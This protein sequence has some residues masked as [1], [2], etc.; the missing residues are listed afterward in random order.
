MYLNLLDAGLNEHQVEDVRRFN[1]VVGQRRNWPR[2]SGGI[3]NPNGLLPNLTFPLVLPYSLGRFNL[4]WHRAADRHCQIAVDE[5]RRRSTPSEC[6]TLESCPLLRSA[7]LAQHATG[8]HA[9][10]WAGEGLLDSLHS[11]AWMRQ[12]I[13]K[14]LSPLECYRDPQVLWPLRSRSRASRVCRHLAVVSRGSAMAAYL[15]VGRV[16]WIRRRYKR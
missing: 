4:L 8:N 14:H 3:Q 11:M 2:F 1:G 16:G 6:R 10:R 7:Y 12:A 13:P 5:S 9:P 15:V